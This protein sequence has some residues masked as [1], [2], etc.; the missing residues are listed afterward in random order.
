MILTEI[1]NKNILDNLISIIIICAFS[2][3][4]L[5]FYLNIQYATYFLFIC[6]ACSFL[7]FS[8]ILINHTNKIIK[9]SLTFAVVSFLRY[10]M[11]FGSVK[12]VDTLIVVSIIFFATVVYLVQLNKTNRLILLISAIVCSLFL[13]I[14]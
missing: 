2:M 10:L 11:F 1:K 7:A 9:L 13:I 5:S 3:I 8:I 14:Y 4:F 12:F 6:I